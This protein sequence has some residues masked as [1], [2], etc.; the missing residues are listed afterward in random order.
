MKL[1]IIVPV[2]NVEAFL[3]KCLDSLLAQTIED[4]EI[5]LVNDG[6]PDNS[7]LIIDRYAAEYPDKIRS[8]TIDNGGQG[9][10]RNFGLDIAQ[11]EF[12]GFVDSDDWI[13]PEMYEKLYEAAVGAEADISLCDMLA[14]YEDGR[15]E[16][17]S[18]RF[19]EAAPMSAAGSSCNKLFRRSLVADMRFPER[20]WY[21]DFAFS[22]KLLMKSAKTVYV[23]EPLYIYRCG[24]PSTMHN[25]NSG[26]NLEII[27]IM[28]EIRPA[29]SEDRRGEFDALLI[30]HVLLDTVNRVAL[31]TGNDKK[32]V[33]KKLRDYVRG[34]IPQLAVCAVFK[35][36][37]RNRR[38]VMWLNYHGLH[39][40]SKLLLALK[41]KLAGK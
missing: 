33:L 32:Q 23:R 1:S 39:D 10:A 35:K 12:I 22:A 38:I 25:N 15:E 2:Y 20:L 28:E 17:Q 27:E 4:F 14:V 5:I 26:R 29:V 21:E 41:R 34:H 16:L 40:V 9:R 6:S 8:L 13:V 3:P 24:Q 19:D 7:Q 36:Q 30:D 37:P 11:G 31:H 18:A